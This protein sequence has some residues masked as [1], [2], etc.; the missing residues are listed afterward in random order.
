M[1]VNI[2]MLILGILMVFI[3]IENVKGNIASIHWYNRRRI[4]E[5]T[6]PKYG[7]LMGIGTLVIAG[8]LIFSAVLNMIVKM[9]IAV[10]IGGAITLITVIVGIAFILYAQF[11]YNKGIF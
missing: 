11:K 6:R 2:P 3:G 8:G 9:N 7:K 10:L 1:A 4:T 5:E